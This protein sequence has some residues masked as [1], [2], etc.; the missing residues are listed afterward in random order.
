M[1]VCQIEVYRLFIK[2]ILGKYL[3][4][5][6]FNP[7]MPILALFFKTLRL[8]FDAE[9]LIRAVAKESFRLYCSQNA[10]ATL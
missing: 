8:A 1:S 6:L 7:L 4:K 3:I 5:A 2:A 9:A 10:I